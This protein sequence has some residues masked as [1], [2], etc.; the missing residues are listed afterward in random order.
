[1]NISLITIQPTNLQ[2]EP[3]PRQERV[4]PN[5]KQREYRGQENRPHHNNSWQ[6]ILLPHKALQKR[7]KMYNHP[8]SKEQPA[9]E[10]APR[11]VS[12]IYSI[13]NPDS[14]PN[15]INDQKSHGRDQKGSPLEETL[16]ECE[17]VR[18]DSTNDPKL[19][20]SPQIIDPDSTPLH[21]ED[22][23]HSNRY[24][25]AHEN[26]T[27]IIADLHM[28]KKNIMLNLKDLCGAHL[29]DDEFSCK[30]AY[31]WQCAINDQWEKSLEGLQATSIS[32][33]NRAVPAQENLD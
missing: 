9:K 11:L 21:L 20:V 27:R 5:P 18:R 28:E 14:H 13:R 16:N 30:Q 3:I 19:L 1:V 26:E 29:R 15:N 2:D 4:Y 17:K 10:W 12:V 23:R 22:A 7:V 33:P 31:S 32:V 8:K 6:P 25:E 24:E